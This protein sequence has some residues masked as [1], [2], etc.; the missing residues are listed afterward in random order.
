MRAAWHP[1]AA[2]TGQGIMFAQQT[3]KGI[4]HAPNAHTLSTHCLTTLDTFEALES[5][6]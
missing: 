6:L 2:G 4:T 3:S 5:T 1:F